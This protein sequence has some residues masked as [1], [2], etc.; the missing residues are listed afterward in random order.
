VLI[1]RLKEPI[2]AFSRRYPVRRSAIMPALYLAQAEY[3]YLSR[4]VME[5]V[6][7]VL[8]VSPVQVYEIATFYSMFHTTPVGRHH[9]QVC[10]NVSCMLLGAE[11]LLAHIEQALGLKAGESSPD[12]LF[13]LSCVECLGSCDTAPVMQVNNEPYCENLSE[14]RIDGILQALREEQVR[15]D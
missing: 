4:E 13:T 3:G 2:E 14:Q 1:A 11:R 10:T 7:E 6:A 12:G 9:L 15:T 8:Q 5:A